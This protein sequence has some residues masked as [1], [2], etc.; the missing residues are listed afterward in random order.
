MG[1][2]PTVTCFPGVCHD[3]A[4]GEIASS[5]QHYFPGWYYLHGPQTLQFL[6]EDWAAVDE[7][8]Q[9]FII[10]PRLTGTVLCFFLEICSFVPVFQSISCAPQDVSYLLLQCV[11]NQLWLEGPAIALWPTLPNNPPS[12]QDPWP[13]ISSTRL[14]LGREPRFFVCCSVLL[15]ST[16]IAATGARIFHPYQFINAVPKEQSEELLNAELATQ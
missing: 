2:S 15:T 14:S 3:K 6:L 16:A 4:Q 8:L 1:S 12:L 11:G 9:K 13:P 10:P 5:S 7:Q